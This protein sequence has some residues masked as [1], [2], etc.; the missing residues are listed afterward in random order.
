[1]STCC[2]TINPLRRDGTSQKQR[3]SL[4]LAEN[5]VRI[6]ERSHADL[7]NFIRGLAL[8]FNYYAANDAVQ[9]TWV[10]FFEEDLSFLLSQNLLVNVQEYRDAV[11]AKLEEVKV[12]YAA[13]GTSITFFALLEELFAAFHTS[14]F[15]TYT[16]QN[17]EAIPVMLSRWH[18]TLPDSALFNNTESYSFRDL[19]SDGRNK[20]SAVL[21]KLEVAHEETNLALGSTLDLLPWNSLKASGWNI[22]A[23]PMGIVLPT[24][25]AT[26]TYYT[27]AD[28]EE[29]LGKIYELLTT[30]MD[31]LAGLIES[32][33]ASVPLYLQQSLA[34]FPWHNPQNALFLAFMQ[35]FEY[36][37][38]HINT[39][40]RKHLLYEYMDVLRFSKRPLVGDEAV[41]IF[42]LRK[43]VPHFLLEEGVLLKA[44]KDVDG[45]PLNY[46]VKLETVVNQAIVRSLMSV[47]V[48]RGSGSKVLGMFGSPVANSADGK[49]LALPAKDPKW[50]MFGEAQMALLPAD[51]TMPDA[52]HGFAIASPLF[53]MK[54]GLREVTVTFVVRDD[55]IPGILL[56]PKQAQLEANILQ[57]FQVTYTH[58]KGWA[59]AR[60]A[61][62][63]FVT[64]QTQV[65]ALKLEPAV[66]S[67]NDILLSIKVV[68]EEGELPVV[69]Y[70]E[71]VHQEGMSTLWPVL[72]FTLTGQTPN[73]ADLGLVHLSQGP[74]ANQGFCLY[75]GNIYQNKTGTS[76]STL[77]YL[78][79]I[80]DF[81][82]FLL[83]RFLPPAYL[84][85]D[86][87]ADYYE[88]D[89]V[90]FNGGIYE[91]L[92]DFS[93]SQI[94]NQN[95]ET[96]PHLWKRLFQGFSYDFLQLL[97]PSK[98][99]LRVDVTGMGG[100]LLENDFGKL[101]AEKPF[102][103]FGGIP[104][105]GS[106]FYIGSQEIFGKHL[107][108]LSIKLLWQD[109]PDNL[110]LHYDDYEDVIANAQGANNNNEGVCG[111]DCNCCYEV[112]KEVGQDAAEGVK[113]Y[114]E[115]DHSAFNDF[116]VC[117]ASCPDTPSFS[118][119]NGN[120]TVDVALLYEGLWEGLGSRAL[121]H[122]EPNGSGAKL[123]HTIS[124]DTNTLKP[125]L[126]DLNLKEP[127]KLESNTPRGF[128]RFELSAPLI[129]FGHKYY[130]D[131]Y[132]K[133]A[134]DAALQI[135]NKQS[136]T[137]DFPGEPYTPVVK[138]MKINYTS[139]ATIDFGVDAALAEVYAERVDQ[140]YH[141]HPFGHTE[142]HAYLHG[143]E[144][145]YLVPQYPE[146]GYLYIGL[147]GL[148]APSTLSVLFQL[149]EG[150]ANPDLEPLRPVWSILVNNRW[151]DLL[152]RDIIFDS[153]DELIA[154]GVIQ[155]DFDAD[156][157]TGNTLLHKDLHWLRVKVNEDTPA[158]MKAVDIVA[159]AV[160]VQ[161]QDQNNNPAHL[162][163]A[164]P[165][166]T[167]NALLVN[168]PQVK[169]VVQPYGSFGGK[170]PELSETFITRV[171]ERLRHKQRAINIW[172][173]ERM[174]LEEFPSV[175]KVKCLNHT[176]YKAE[177][178]ASLDWEISPGFVT[179]V[180]IP[181]LR[182]LNGINPFEPKTSVRTLKNVD[183]F[184]RRYISAW[185][186]LKVTN[187]LYEVIK[188]TCK[189]G[190]VPGKDPGYYTQKLE[191]A[192][193][194]FLSPWAFDHEREIVFGGRIH[195]SH[196]IRFIEQEE[197]VDFVIAFEMDHIVNG[198]THENVEEASATKG[199]SILV[200]A[201]SHAITSVKADCGD[202]IVT[203][204]HAED[205]ECCSGN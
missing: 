112:E 85:Y 51:R 163:K 166:H 160:L 109:P 183:T 169:S 124:F 198:V 135:S 77:T 68:I 92:K 201:T 103:M 12:E 48:E 16:S 131:L 22:H 64:N 173:Y 188:I 25:P 190:F 73:C 28:P 156:F 52:R 177:H 70:S 175:Y 45:N 6:D 46:A 123:P 15:S 108:T 127:G 75:G 53:V 49:G 81:S 197:Y 184:L 152:R 111:K 162:A 90:H 84:P 55:M 39:L 204:A 50:N 165:S 8:E 145:I 203:A 24:P 94:P 43:G 93:Q 9:G 189:V 36:A 20:L 126:R 139:K 63:Y 74:V 154:T 115:W 192:I 200:S 61:S 37:Q 167:I 148:V 41:V 54:E 87:A 174:V 71:K 76:Q 88:T 120:W 138:E 202:C 164:L 78:T 186:D 161:F 23:M 185:V 11:A 4:A 26:L 7:L 67:G 153:T 146:E 106:R 191:V 102:P 14:L 172:D 1:M 151:R 107:D 89:W 113:Y 2:K 18:A 121:F 104:V 57:A 133:A 119:G 98:L 38:S 80:S 147:E 180:C 128:L 47:H 205:V 155:F 178:T 187:P 199:R 30:S 149:A 142:E 31:A 114:G 132:V 171:S 99:H 141:I 83:A 143:G 137:P 122:V 13:F 82:K 86:E 182:N 110:G 129:A 159:Q 168:D 100:V 32:L 193:Q 34:Q 194:Q 125:Y 134:M 5:Y 69:P 95:P 130:R 140:F 62:V 144:R 10:E 66:V 150:S 29:D 116:P 21:K 176:E 91:A 170:L 65:A 105:I 44:G 117:Y 79:L 101:K 42:G 158:Y 96:A 136:P 97:S 19:V 60:I 27:S 58:A 195:R 33:Q 56:Q 157:N 72:R 59:S 179:V 40:G 118:L 35:L 196:I 3:F 17:I 181:D